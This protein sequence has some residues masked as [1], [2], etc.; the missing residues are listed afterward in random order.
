MAAFLAKAIYG[1]ETTRQLIDRLSNDRQ[2]RCLC[3]W[4]HRCHLPHESTFSRAFE[5]A[6]SQL[7]QRLHEAL[8]LHTHK[9]RLI[10]HIER[11][12]TAI[13]CVKWF[14]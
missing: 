5:F 10:G 8:I 13:G 11:D 12:S 2:L 6:R 3:G 7:P 1:L 4:N 14:V 9:D